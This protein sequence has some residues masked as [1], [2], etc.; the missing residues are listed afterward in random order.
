MTNQ[1]VEV[2][3]FVLK[4]F[5]N[6]LQASVN[7]FYET[8]NEKLV[9]LVE[10]AKKEDEEKEA[11][12]AALTK[13]VNEGDSIAAADIPDGADSVVRAW[14]G[15]KDALWG[16]QGRD[17]TE[18]VQGLLMSGSEAVQASDEVF[19]DPAPGIGKV[20][21]IEL[22][23][24]AEEAA[25]PEDAAPAEEAEAAA[26]EAAAPE[27]K[28]AADTGVALTRTK[29]SMERQVKVEWSYLT[30]TGEFDAAQGKLVPLGPNEAA[31]LALKRAQKRD[32]IGTA[33]SKL[34]HLHSERAHL[35]S[36]GMSLDEANQLAY[37]RAGLALPAKDAAPV[38]MSKC[39][40]V[41]KEIV[42]F[43]VPDDVPTYK[44]L[45][46]SM[47]ST[48]SEF[49]F[50]LERDP[51]GMMQRDEILEQ[52]RCLALPQPSGVRLLPGWLACSPLLL[53][54]FLCHCQ[55]LAP[56]ALHL[57][58]PCSDKPCTGAA[59]VCQQGW[60]RHQPG[61]GNGTRATARERRRNRGRA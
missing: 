3:E 41:F 14:Y 16:E 34:R 51:D 23:P 27:D 15:N 39:I 22:A 50:L 2:A 10:Q 57:L 35:L 26:P 20:L 8:P 38:W 52:V 25:A 6:N 46:A 11:A 54:C 4:K 32:T 58:L 36:T 28:D 61:S 56:F 53:C 5:N 44:S 31:A 18:E 7:F 24:K 29:S 55:H 47:A 30:Q 13:I 21:A 43:D 49:K 40:T 9:E 48:A 1:T 12:K 45:V 17:V 19:E 59:V 60:H 37:H 42:D 33:A